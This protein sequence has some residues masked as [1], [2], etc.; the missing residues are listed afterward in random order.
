MGYRGFSNCGYSFKS[1][2]QRL[3]QSKYY[4]VKDRSYSIPKALKLT[5]VEGSYAKTWANEEGIPC[6]YAAP[7]GK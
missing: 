5:V 3:L 4:H 1:G 7:T 6:V 2:F